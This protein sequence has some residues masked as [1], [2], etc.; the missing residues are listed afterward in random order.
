VALDLDDR[1]AALE[2]VHRCE[3]VAWFKVGLQLYTRLGPGIVQALVKAGKRVFLDLKFH[4]IPNTVGQAAR[5]AVQAGAGLLTV[6]A[7]GGKVMMEAARAAVEGS[8]TRVLAVTVLTSLSD[9]ELQREVGLQET[10]SEAVARLSVLAVNAGTHGIVCSP[11]EAALVRQAVGPGPVIVTP[12]VRPAWAAD[13]HDD[14][15]RVMTPSDAAR[16]GADMIVVGRPILR[17]PDPAEA[18]QRITEE[19]QT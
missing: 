7:T 2:M 3:G 18:V 6:H 10:G 16:A 19:L 12:G 11:R 9:A 1:D 14:Q 8:E 13:A 17:H 4:D 5:A 15:Q